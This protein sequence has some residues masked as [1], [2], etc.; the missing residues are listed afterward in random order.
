[1]RMRGHAN[2]YNSRGHQTGDASSGTLFPVAPFAGKAEWLTVGTEQDASIH[3]SPKSVP[4]TARGEKERS[5][6]VAHLVRSVGQEERPV[7]AGHGV[8]LSRGR[9]RVSRDVSGGL[10]CRLS[11]E[12]AGICVRTCTRQTKAKHFFSV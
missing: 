12:H 5:E 1:M 2:R 10:V 4:G 8:R 11:A 3:G 6:E 9:C 7:R